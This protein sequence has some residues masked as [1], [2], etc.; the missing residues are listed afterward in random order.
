MAARGPT[1]VAGSTEPPLPQERLYSWLTADASEEAT[2]S[3]AEMRARCRA[4]CVALRRRWGAST[5]DR[6]MLVY[7]PGLELLVAFFGCQYAAVIAVPYY[8]PVLPLTPLPSVGAKRLLADGLAKVKRIAESCTPHAFLSTR[9]YVRASW[10]ASKLVREA[11]CSWPPEWT[12]RCTD[13]A[14]TTQPRSLAPRSLL[15]PVPSTLSHST[16]QTPP[17][18]PHPLAP[19]SRQVSPRLGRGDADW[20]SEWLPGRCEP[21]PRDEVSFLQYTST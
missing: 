17:P 8:P 18:P 15:R 16:V 5:N 2:L 13:E 3:Y 7:A 12:W 4:V 6:L 9:T 19:P 10:L 21:S 11:E 20:L 1:G 14:R